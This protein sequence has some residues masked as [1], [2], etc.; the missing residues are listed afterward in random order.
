M[1]EQPAGKKAEGEGRALAPEPS[2]VDPYWGEHGV[3]I[4][5]SPVIRTWSVGARYPKIKG[6]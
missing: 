2:K 5:G 3:R 1:T 6:T 4:N